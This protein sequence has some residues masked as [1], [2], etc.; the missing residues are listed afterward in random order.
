MWHA[1]ALSALLE[2]PVRGH[3]SLSPQVIFSD[4]RQ[5]DWVVLQVCRVRGWVGLSGR[6][7]PGPWRLWRPCLG[8]VP[9]GCHRGRACGKVSKEEDCGHLAVP[10][11]LAR[12]VVS[13]LKINFT[14]GCSHQG[15]PWEVSVSKACGHRFRRPWRQFGSRGPLPVPSPGAFLLVRE[16]LLCTSHATLAL[17]QE[18]CLFYLD[19]ESASLVS[20]LELK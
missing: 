3:R 12:M 5:L 18:L 10:K 14:P 13:D 16:P 15:C 11:Q 4:Q 19:L 7:R 6:L 1:T 20:S 2:L 17:H 8:S 9:R